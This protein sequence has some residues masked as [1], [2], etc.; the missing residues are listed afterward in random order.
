MRTAATP[1]LASPAAGSAMCICFMLLRS[2]S[3]TTVRLVRVA[4]IDGIGPSRCRCLLAFSPSCSFTG[5]TTGAD[6][7]APTSICGIRVETSAWTV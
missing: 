5:D 3:V 7:T 1:I 2:L 6:Q 4:E